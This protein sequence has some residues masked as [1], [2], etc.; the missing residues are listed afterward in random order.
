M[1]EGILAIGPQFA[2]WGVELD[3]SGASSAGG[4]EAELFVP[5]SGAE[6]PD[7]VTAQAFISEQ[8]K[9][10]VGW[11]QRVWKLIQLSQVS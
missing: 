5:T 2:A 1:L 10:C 3:K 8:A 6:G 7:A 11:S 4:D 9:S